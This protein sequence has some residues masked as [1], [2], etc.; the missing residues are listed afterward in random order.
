MRHVVAT[1]STPCATPGASAPCVLGTHGDGGWVVAS[2]TCA[3]D[4][5]GAEYVRGHRARRGPEDPRMARSTSLRPRSPP[6]PRGAVHLRARLL[7]PPRLPHL[8]RERGPGPARVRPPPRPG[9]PRRG[10]RGHRRAGQRQLRRPRLRRGER[11]PLRARACCATTTWA[12]PSSS[13]PRTD[14]DFGARMKYNPVREVLAGKR[15]VV[16]DDSLVRGTTSRSLVAI[17]REAGAKEV[18]FRIASPPGALPL[19]LRHRHAHPGGA[20]RRPALGRGDPPAARRGLPGLPLP[21]GDAGG[22]AARRPS[23]PPASR[24]TTPPLSSI[25]TPD[26]RSPPTAEALPHSGIRAT[27]AAS[28]PHPL[29]SPH[30]PPLVVSCPLTAQA[31]GRSGGAARPAGTLCPEERRAPG[32]RFVPTSSRG[33]A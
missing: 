28:A 4:I 3:L 13:R 2:E 20:H 18:H 17:I 26:S 12:G 25:S 5:I 11:H 15:V 30:G 29:P 10:R 23:A 6:A 22:R 8:G 19:L 1:R 14:R 21:G 27:T 24:A 31:H 32:R 9:A 33:T 7:R 16:V